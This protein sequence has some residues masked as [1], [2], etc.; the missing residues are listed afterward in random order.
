MSKLE[1]VQQLY[2]KN[3]DIN[4]QTTINTSKDARYLEKLNR[5]I[6]ATKSFIKQADLAIE[7]LRTKESSDP[8]LE[9][10]KRIIAHYDAYS[11]LPFV[12]D[13]DEVIDVA[14]SSYL[15]QQRV[16]NQKEIIEYIQ[17]SSTKL[18]VERLEND[19]SI[20]KSVLS[21]I[22]ES[23]S[24]TETR[25]HLLESKIDEVQSEDYKILDKS[26]EIVNEKYKEME[27]MESLVSS[28]LKRSI[29]KF[30]A[31][32]N[33]EDE[34]VLDQS[35]LR[36]A[37]KHTL[38]TIIQLLTAPKNQWVRIV[39]NQYSEKLLRE[40]ILNDLLIRDD[41]NQE[42]FQLRHFGTGADAYD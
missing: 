39:P 35:T 14:T 37:L 32:Q 19:T 8:L 27:E 28:H 11:K 24:K 36:H 41:S 26:G 3:G 40:L 1:R 13:K 16:D 42:Y 2:L 17:L 21:D 7:S 18:Q 33:W 5:E 23:I 22:M 6:E 34:T 10:K 38:K 31:L 25:L 30:F 9:K 12:S 15:V 4:T 29:T 20:F